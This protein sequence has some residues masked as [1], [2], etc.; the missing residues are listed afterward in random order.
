M[1]KNSRKYDYILQ[2]ISVA[3]VGTSYVTYVTHECLDCYIYFKKIL[4]EKINLWARLNNSTGWVQ[5]AD[6]TLFSPDLQYLTN[7]TLY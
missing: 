7:S 4:N 2:C 3:S 5:T 1:K 6:C